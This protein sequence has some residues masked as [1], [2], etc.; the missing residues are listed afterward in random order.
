MARKKKAAA[1]AAAETQAGRESG[2]KKAE[3]GAKT[4]SAGGESASLGSKAGQLKEFF[5]ESKVEIKKVHWPSRKETIATCIAVLV[6]TTV[7]AVYLGVVD[8]ALSAAIEAI[9]AR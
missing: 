5:E 9:L 6:L 7:M 1:S 3:G 2:K 4:A 8:M